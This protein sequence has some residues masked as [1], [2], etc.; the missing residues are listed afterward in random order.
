MPAKRGMR[1]QLADKST[2]FSTTNDQKK[3]AVSVVSMPVGSIFSFCLPADARII[4]AFKEYSY[5]G[6]IFGSRW[7]GLVNFD[8]FYSRASCGRYEKHHFIQSDIS[9]GQHGAVGV[10]RH[11]HCGDGR[12]WFKKTAQT[13]MFLPYFISWSRFSAFFYNISIR[14]RHYERVAP[15]NRAEPNDIYS[16]PIYGC[17]APAVL[18]LK[19]IGFSS[20]LYLSAIMARIRKATNRPRSMREHFQRIWYITIPLL[21][22]TIITLVLLGLSRSWPRVRHVYQLIGTTACWR[23]RRILSTP[24][25]S[26]PHLLER[27]RMSSAGGVYQSVLSF[28]INYAVKWLVK[29][30][31]SDYALY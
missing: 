22:P 29:K 24:S 18:R 3:N 30:W 12:R 11:P 4:I 13:F 25:S 7:N 6:G 2:V 31:N 10:R 8:Y 9:D 20:V 27:L 1:M 5:D 14:L 19:G 16:N 28:F 21:T 23:T 17:S 26:A 15:V